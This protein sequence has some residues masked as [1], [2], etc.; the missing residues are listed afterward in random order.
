[1]S[2]KESFGKF[3]ADEVRDYF[4]Q[5]GFELEEDHWRE[6]GLGRMAT[7]LKYSRRPRELRM[8]WSD[9]SDG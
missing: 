7:K 4:E 2:R 9:K 8:W 3:K 1:M 6:I 5:V